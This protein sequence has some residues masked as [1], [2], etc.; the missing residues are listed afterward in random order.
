MKLCGE[1]RKRIWPYLIVVLFS[2][3]AGLIMWLTLSAAGVPE[4]ARRMWTIAVFLAVLG[5]QFTYIISCMRRH[6]GGDH[7][8]G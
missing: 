7:H 1:C 5:L 2:A 8:S 3:V 4:D 6:C